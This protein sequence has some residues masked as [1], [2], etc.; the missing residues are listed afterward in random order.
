[1]IL[2]IYNSL[3]TVVFFLPKTLIGEIKISIG[4]LDSEYGV[5][6]SGITWVISPLPPSFVLNKIR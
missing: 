4:T 2:P 6:S 5:L 1:M 3:I